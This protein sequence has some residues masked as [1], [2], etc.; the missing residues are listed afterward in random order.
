MIAESRYDL[1]A[2]CLHWITAAVLI[3]IVVPAG[4]WIHYFEPAD[5]A[6]SFA[7][8]TRLLRA[9]ESGNGLYE[10]GW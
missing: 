4:I 6:T 1:I 9:G 8:C 2:R 10:P 3:A 5:Q 7:G